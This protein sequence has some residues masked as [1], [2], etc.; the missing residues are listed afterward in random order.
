MNIRIVV[1]DRGWVYVCRMP[2]PDQCGMW[3]TA[4]DA[5]CIRRWGTSD[6]L[7]ELKGGPLAATQLSPKVKSIQF[8]IRAVIS[9]IEVEES[10][11]NSH[12]A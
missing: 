7:E 8:P 1:L 4:T 9:V 2:N 10:K 12:L 5:R 6:G 11:W 3:I